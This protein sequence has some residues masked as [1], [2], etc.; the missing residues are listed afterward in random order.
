[1]VTTVFWVAVICSFINFVLVSVLLP[2]SLDKVKRERAA[3]EYNVKAAGKGKTPVPET[4]EGSGSQN[5][6]NQGK[7]GGGIVCEFL[8]PLGVFLPVMVMDGGVR[9]RRDWS[10]TCLAAALFGYMLSQVSDI[11][12]LVNKSEVYGCILYRECIKWS[13][14]TQD[15]FMHGVLSNSVIIYH[16]LEVLGRHVYY[17]FCHVSRL[18]NCVFWSSIT[19]YG[20]VV[21]ISAL[22]PKIGHTNLNAPPSSTTTNKGKKPLPTKA[23]LAQEIKFDLFLTRCSF[24]IDL[25]S[26]TFVMLSPMPSY[27]IHGLDVMGD[28]SR[29]SKEPSQ[30]LFVFATSLSSLG[31]GAVPAM[32]SLA[33]C[34]LQMRALDAGE[35]DGGKAEGVGSLFGALAMLQAIGQMILGVSIQLN[36]EGLGYWWWLL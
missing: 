7:R 5:E 8:R 16:S 1:M 35:T 10:L 23:H 11:I 27:K 32:Q 28:P 22:K 30:A 6:D 17:S 33:L 24:M 36:T 29:H 12:Y 20:F 31:S 25:L 26:H 14:Y 15:T 34:I 2:E 4:A 21:I 18:P 19:L 13:I 9:K 3:L